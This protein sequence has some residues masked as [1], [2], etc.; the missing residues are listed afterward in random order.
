MILTTCT[1]LLSLMYFM[2]LLSICVRILMRK[3]SMCVQIPN[4]IRSLQNILSICIK[5]WCILWA[6]SQNLMHRL[7]IG[8]KIWCC[9]ARSK[10]MGQLDP[11]HCWMFT[12]ICTELATCCQ[13]YYF[14]IHNAG[15]T[16]YVCGSMKPLQYCDR[17]VSC[18]LNLRRFRHISNNHDI[19]TT[20]SLATNS[21]DIGAD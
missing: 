17:Q 20:Q 12:P 1:L 5:I 18:G 2:P 16:Q 7:S 6:Y 14:L 21:I 3:L 4:F 19:Y 8:V 15:L 10:R 11:Q 9:P 13:P